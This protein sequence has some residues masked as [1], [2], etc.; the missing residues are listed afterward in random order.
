MSG[1]KRGETTARYTRMTDLSHAA[2]AIAET[3]N[4][5]LDFDDNRTWGPTLTAALSGLLKDSTFDKLV[6]ASPQYIEDACEL[7]FSCADRARIV[8]A[9]LVW[10]RST[11]IMGYHGGRLNQCEVESIRARGL[12]PLEAHARRARLTRALSPHPTWG[13]VAHLLDAALRDYGPGE[14]AGRRE[15]QVHLT[16]SRCG[17]VNGFNNYLTYGSEFDRRVAH[18]LLGADGA[19]LLRAYG[20]ATVIQAAVPGDAALNAVN[21]YFT[22]DERLA[23]GEVPDL[24]DDFLKAWSYGLAHPDFDCG[25]LHVDCGLVFRS[26]VPPA[27][28]VGIDTVSA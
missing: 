19:E 9:T 27:W 8:D 28:I 26:A 13:Q 1:Q 2:T 15:G 20:R 17:L 16:L 18:A 6:A 25:T 23:R 12:L 4:D 24:V 10:I 3:E 7:L 14:R 11:S 21:R 22:V 5:V